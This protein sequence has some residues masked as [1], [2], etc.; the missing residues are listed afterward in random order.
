M[1]MLTKRLAIIMTFYLHRLSEGKATAVKTFKQTQAQFEDTSAYSEVHDTHVAANIGLK[2]L[3][4]DLRG[5]SLLECPMFELCTLLCSIHV[6]KYLC[7]STSLHDIQ[8]CIF[9]TVP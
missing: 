1:L 5:V 3:S 9:H 2:W 7:F 4:W 8:L 6:Q